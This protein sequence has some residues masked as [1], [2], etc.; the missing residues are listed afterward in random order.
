M[1]SHIL[2]LLLKDIES[3]KTLSDH[4]SVCKEIVK[5]FKLKHIPNAILNEKQ[6][7]N[8]Q[9]LKLPVAT[10]WG[11][12]VTCMESIQVN[13]QLL[14]ECLIHPDIETLATNKIKSAILNDDVFW[15]RNVKFIELLNPV[16]RLITFMEN[17]NATLS[18]T[19]C[20]F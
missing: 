16:V 2:N 9:S 20:T 5:F 10:K 14:K 7:V 18:G 1:Q 8:F 6:G 17:T 11:S 19:S 13:K 15:D 3:L 4:L 12:T